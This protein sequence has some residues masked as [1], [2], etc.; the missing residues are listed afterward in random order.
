MCKVVIQGVYHLEF[1]GRGREIK[2]SL[3][4]KQ[5]TSFLSDAVRTTI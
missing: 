1:S 2:F 3:G 4:T 5:Q